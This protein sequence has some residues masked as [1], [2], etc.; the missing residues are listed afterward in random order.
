MIQ[1]MHSVS[2]QAALIPYGQFYKAA[3]HNPLSDVQL[4]LTCNFVTTIFTPFACMPGRASGTK[5]VGMAEMGAPISLDC[6]CVS[7]CYLYFAPENP[8]DGEMYL[9]VPA[10]PCCPGQSPESC[11]MVACVCGTDP[12]TSQTDGQTTRNRKTMVSTIVHRV[13]TGLHLPFPIFAIPTIF[14]LDALPG[15]TLP[16]YPGLRQ[17]PNM[18]ACIPDGL[19]Q[20]HI[21]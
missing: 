14:T 17:A 7:L 20:D 18:L 10:H 13:V 3:S 1:C 9:L 12:P 11:K 16:I 6:W 5:M 4:W 2:V 15:T 19:D 8:E 21:G